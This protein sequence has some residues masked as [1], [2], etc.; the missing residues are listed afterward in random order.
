MIAQRL[1]E[2]RLLECLLCITLQL[3][4]VNISSSFHFILICFGFWMNK[5]NANIGIKLSSWFNKTN[6]NLFELSS[7]L[8]SLGLLFSNG[9]SYFIQSTYSPAETY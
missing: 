2:K 9:D 6:V 5:D 3:I 4:S 8:T 7:K 1:F